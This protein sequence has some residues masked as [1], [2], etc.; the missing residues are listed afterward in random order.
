M[1]ALLEEE[2][3]PEGQLAQIAAPPKGGHVALPTDE[4]SR[5]RVVPTWAS[6]REIN[7]MGEIPLSRCHFFGT[8]ATNLA[9]V[10]CIFDTGGARSCIDKGTALK[11]KLPVVRAHQGESGSFWGLGG[12]KV[13]Y[14]GHV[15]GPIDLQLSPQVHMQLHE[16]KVVD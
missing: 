4:A 13:D 3:P 14:W 2:D 16:L 7:L 8:V 15:K 10:E 1:L 9:V 6:G 5:P 11:M 12:D